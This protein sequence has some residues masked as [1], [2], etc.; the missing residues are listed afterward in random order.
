MNEKLKKLRAQI[1]EN[2]AKLRAI[3]DLAETEKR[4][5]TEDEVKAY[6]A[7][8]AETDK[9]EKDHE[10]EEKLAIRE[11]RARDREDTVYLADFNSRKKAP[12]KEFS[13]FGEFAYTAI[14][15][16][17][18]PRLQD[19]YQ[20]RAQSMG[21]GTEGGFAIPE[22]FLPEIKQVQPGA[23]VVRPRATVIPA[24][25]PPDAK[26]SM[27]AL[28][29]TNAENIYGGVVVAAVAEAGLKSET[30][31][32][33][34]EV[35]LEPTEVAGWIRVSDKLLRNWGAASAVLSTQ[36][37]KAIVGWEDY[38]FLRGT[39]VAEPLGIAN[40]P[41]RVTV[42]RQTA[43]S[44]TW[45]DV[46][47]MYSRL[48]FGGNPVWIASQTCLPTMMTIADGGS[49]NLFVTAFAGAAGAVPSTFFGF[50]ILFSDRSPAVGTEG[51]L[52][53]VDLSYY[54]IKDGSGPF[55]DAS[56]HVYFTNN[57]TVIKI[58]FNVD[59]KP[60]LTQPIGLEGSVTNT[61]SPF[62]VLQ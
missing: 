39:G 20:A 18:D 6:D 13:C 8:Q 31:I 33:L 30:D 49:N 25:D 46:R 12:A 19:L 41:A 62:V 1:E 61:V 56:P 3:L 21:V 14:Y 27:P 37:R 55:I 15:N 52:M 35:S 44:V 43:A 47:T 5:L 10:R 36:L 51:D 53:L 38:R 45:Q 54:L 57:Q 58:F 17:S 22:Q 60:W 48:R 7:L 23:A 50:P 59:G 34:R 9:L 11:G 26:I 2:L 24:G 42:T 29:Q 4:D 32:R 28:D 16:R 40:S